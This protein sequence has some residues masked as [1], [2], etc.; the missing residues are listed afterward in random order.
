[1]FILSFSKII[2]HLIDYL[3]K[4]VQKFN[5]IIINTSKIINILCVF[6]ASY[7]F[8]SFVYGI[9]SGRVSD[10]LETADELIITVNTRM[11]NV[12]LGKIEYPT[13]NFRYFYCN[14]YKQY[15]SVIAELRSLR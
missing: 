11:W 12:I 13:L 6:I 8:I 1:M 7:N 2:G 10:R 14:R 3:S 4:Y 15:L 5:I 9:I